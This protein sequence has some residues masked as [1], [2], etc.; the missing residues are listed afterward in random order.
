M[1]HHRVGDW[2]AA[3]LALE[4]AQ[5]LGFLDGA[6]QFCQAVARWRLGDRDG[7]LRWYHKGVAWMGDH[8]D[9]RVARPFYD[10]AAALVKPA[11][12]SENQ[13][14]RRQ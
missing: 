9:D 7:A 10:E 8:S 13:S 6:G 4:R 12:P 5:E 14:K 2:P 11:V 3:A 1:A